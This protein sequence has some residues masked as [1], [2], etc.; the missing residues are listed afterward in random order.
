MWRG[1]HS[2]KPVQ[3]GVVGRPLAAVPVR[4][5]NNSGVEAIVLGPG[6]MAP[7]ALEIIGSDVAATAAPIPRV[8]A[9]PDLSPGSCCSAQDPVESDPL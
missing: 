9:E 6:L 8:H 7:L 2:E 1:H 5:A 3:R 4:P